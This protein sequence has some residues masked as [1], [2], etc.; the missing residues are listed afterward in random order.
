MARLARRTQV[1]EVMCRLDAQTHRRFVKTHTPLDG[2]PIDERAR[3]TSWWPAIRSTW[4]CRSI[5]RATTSTAHGS[6]SSRASGCRHRR[7]PPG[8]R[9]WLRWIDW[10]P[11]P[12]AQMDSLPGVMAHLSDA[13]ARREEPN[14]VLVHYDDLSAD[15]EAEMRRI[16]GRLEVD[17]PESCRPELAAAAGFD[18]MRARADQLA[19]DAAGVLKDPARFF[20]RGRSGAARGTALHRRARSLRCAGPCARPAPTPGVAPS[21]A[22]GA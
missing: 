16:A 12:R 2:I 20:R 3:P 22:R 9:G 13:W 4:P 1:N 19:P 18:R 7:A 6:A 21:H 14:V 11:D 17:V 15:L 8:S 5:T 10:D